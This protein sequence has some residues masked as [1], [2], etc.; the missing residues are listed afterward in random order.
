MLRA[1]KPV[2]ARRHWVRT[3]FV[4]AGGRQVLRAASDTSLAASG[5]PFCSVSASKSVSATSPRSFSNVVDGDVLKA[6]EAEDDAREV[7]DRRLRRGS[8]KMSGAN[9][10]EYW[11][12]QVGLLLTSGAAIVIL[13]AGWAVDHQ[14][15]FDARTSKHP[16]EFIAAVGLLTGAAIY[17]MFLIG[18][19]VWIYQTK[20]N[21]TETNDKTVLPR[22]PAITIAAALACFALSIAILMSYAKFDAK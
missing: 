11:R 10:V 15:K 4:A 19:V 3:S 20:L 7:F 5:R 13:F 12:D 2:V 14:E 8:S 16:A 17:A 1:G 21:P 22:W 18:S 9:V 6:S